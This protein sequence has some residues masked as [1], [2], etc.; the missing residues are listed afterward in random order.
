MGRII[1]PL[2]VSL[3][4]AIVLIFGW[5]LH[6]EVVI[7]IVPGMFPT[8]KA[9]TAGCMLIAGLLVYEISKQKP[10]YGLVAMYACWIGFLLSATWCITADWYYNNADW[11]GFNMHRGV[12]SL[13][14]TAALL[15]IAHLG[16]MESVHRK[17]CIGVRKFTSG[18]CGI[19]S[20]C[21]IVG[22]IAGVPWLFFFWPGISTGVAVVTAVCFLTLMA[23]IVPAIKDHPVAANSVEARLKAC[24]S[25]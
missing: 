9:T 17:K 22:L 23:S 12:P 13:G 3:A 25:S 16:I 11:H 2:A 10:F 19:V 15:A 18:I 8:M 4:S 5:V 1:A 20:L 21:S 24:R 14:S 6:N 7:A